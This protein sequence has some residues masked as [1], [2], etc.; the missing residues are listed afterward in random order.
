MKRFTLR[1]RSTAALNALAAFGPGGATAEDVAKRCGQITR[2]VAASLSWARR[3][4]L[5]RYDTLSAKWHLA[6]DTL[7]KEPVK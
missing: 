6:D 3:G 2:Q 7:F 4:G 5:T 1:A